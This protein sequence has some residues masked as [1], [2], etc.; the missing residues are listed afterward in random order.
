M[1]RCDLRLGPGHI[2]QSV[3]ASQPHGISLMA[4]RQPHFALENCG[5]ERIKYFYVVEERFSASSL[6][7]PSLLGLHEA[8]ISFLP[9]LRVCYFYFI[10]VLSSVC[11]LLQNCRTLSTSVVTVLYGL[12][13]VQ[14]FRQ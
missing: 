9:A 11:V 1:E 10:F 2:V 5:L 6:C 4:D 12:F 7:F 8:V 3:L 14:Q 13:N